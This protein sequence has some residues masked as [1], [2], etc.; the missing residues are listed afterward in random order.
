MDSS[1]TCCLSLQPPPRPKDNKG[2][3]TS[4]KDRRD[5]W[6]APPRSASSAGSDW[7]FG[8]VEKRSLTVTST[9]T[10]PLADTGRGWGL[11][12]TTKDQT[13]GSRKGSGD[14][15]NSSGGWN[16]GGSKKDSGGEAS[17]SWGASNSSKASENDTASDGWGNHL[18]NGWGKGGWGRRRRMGICSGEQRLERRW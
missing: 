17:S 13:S 3:G 7:N 14:W 16:I 10:T 8:G 12:N 9:N 6:D 5:S 1:L 11:P 18:A 15:G 2:W 4:D